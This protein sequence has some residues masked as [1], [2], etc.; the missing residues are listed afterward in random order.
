MF[1]LGSG[2]TSHI[3][4]SEKNVKNLKDATI[5]VTIVNSINFTGVKS[6]NWPGYQIRDGKIHR[7]TL[8]NTYI[9]PGLHANIFSL[10]LGNPFEVLVSG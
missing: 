5:Q 1:I 9:I 6:I 8:S 3:V 4:N 7:I 2:A 10:S